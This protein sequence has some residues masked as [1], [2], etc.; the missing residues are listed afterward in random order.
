MGITSEMRIYTFIHR[1]KDANIT[2]LVIICILTWPK[3]NSKPYIPSPM[4]H[5]TN[6]INEFPSKTLA[7]DGFGL[8][9]IERSQFQPTPSSPHIHPAPF[10]TVLAL[11]VHYQEFPLQPNFNHPSTCPTSL[12]VNFLWVSTVTTR[13]SRNIHGQ[14]LPG[15]FSEHSHPHSPSGLMST[16]PPRSLNTITVGGW[17]SQSRELIPGVSFAPDSLMCAGKSQAH[18]HWHLRKQWELQDV[19]EELRRMLNDCL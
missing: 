1:I 2:K 3:Y 18:A 12:P 8:P 19:W 6:I 15:T 11:T 13:H 4:F 7:L 9:P 10:T 17:E 5:G 16:S 14:I